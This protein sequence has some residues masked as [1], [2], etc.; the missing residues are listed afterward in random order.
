MLYQLA[1]VRFFELYQQI[2]S[3]LIF[4]YAIDYVAISCGNPPTIPNGFGTFMGTTFGDTTTYTCNTG[5]QSSGLPTVTCQANGSW[6]A[7]PTCTSKTC[8]DPIYIIITRVTGVMGRACSQYRWFTS[9]C[10]EYL[11][12]SCS[13]RACLASGVSVEKI[14][15]SLAYHHERHLSVA[16][17]RGSAGLS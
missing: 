14:H 2:K 5:Y 11:C 6:S 16:L 7:R 15:S 9:M 4:I 13:R 10:C 17:T 8:I 1:Q 12:L 3:A